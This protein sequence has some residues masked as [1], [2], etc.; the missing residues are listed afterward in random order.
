[1]PGAGPIEVISVDAN[2]IIGD[3][4]ADLR[5]GESSVLLR[6]ID[7]E[8]AIAVMS[9]QAFFEVGRITAPVARRNGIDHD[10][11]RA[12][13]TEEYL[14]RIRVV[15]VATTTAPTTAERA[16]SET[17]TNP[18][19]GARSSPWAW[20]PEVTDV[21]DPDDVPHVQ[22]G[23]LISGTAIYSHDKHLKRPGH[24][25]RTREE[26]DE[27]LANLEVV[28]SQREAEQSFPLL[29]VVVG[30]GVNEVVTRVAT[31]AGANRG[32]AWAFTLGALGATAYWALTT[33]ARRDRA[34]EAFGPVATSLLRA[35][36]RAGLAFETLSGARLL[37][38]FDGDRLEVRV[39]SHLVRNPGLS[40]GAMSEALG[41]NTK[42]RRDLSGLLRT[43]PAFEKSGRGWAVGQFRTALETEPS[44][45]WRP[46]PAPT[47]HGPHGG[48]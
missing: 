45:D 12:L 32:V 29:A 20:M 18:D 35:Y 39:A 8:A 16:E 40:M 6:A 2:V 43:H 17:Q 38:T 13:L 36:E 10:N 15:K 22:V 37:A 28:S 1:M 3:A 25:P 26:F 19:N 4:V 14:P 7:A 21:T 31:R 27:R 42:E 30:K 44:P 46:R 41:L 24:A 5:D 33:P 11:L 9:G 34:A 48:R 47:Q 23:R